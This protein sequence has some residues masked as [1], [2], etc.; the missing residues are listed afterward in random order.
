[1][2]RS[3]HLPSHLESTGDGTGAAVGWL[4]KYLARRLYRELEELLVRLAKL[5]FT[6]L[7]LLPQAEI[8]Q[9]CLIM[10]AEAIDEANP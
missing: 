2:T 7:L 3:T 5:S 9:Q 1:L 4:W 10:F 6:P 8:R